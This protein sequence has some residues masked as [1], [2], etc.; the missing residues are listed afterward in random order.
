[1]HILLQHSCYIWSE[2][3]ELVL[4]DSS[5]D[6]N[7]HFLSCSSQDRPSSNWNQIHLTRNINLFPQSKPIAAEFIQ[8]FYS[9]HLSLWLVKDMLLQLLGI[10]FGWSPWMH[11]KN[12]NCIYVHTHQHLEL[13][14][15]IYILWNSKQN[16]FAGWY[17][18][19]EELRF[20][21]ATKQCI[22]TL[23]RGQRTRK[24]RTCKF[25]LPDRKSAPFFVYL[26]WIWSSAIPC[27]Y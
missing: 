5:N 15:A 8:L 23:D 19:N 7:E 2:D 9:S 4:G 25:Y 1:M 13:S 24:R 26:P 27:L 21:T 11:K 14:I 17:R 12:I 6:N 22:T 20:S 16:H 10:Y 18:K 3:S